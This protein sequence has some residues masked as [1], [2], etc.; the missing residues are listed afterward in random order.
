MRLTDSEKQELLR[1]IL[2]V[3]QSDSGGLSSRKYA[4]NHP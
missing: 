3:I 2:S 4:N 1:F